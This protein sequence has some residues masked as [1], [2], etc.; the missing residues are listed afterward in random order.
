VD[1][2]QEVVVTEAIVLREGALCRVSPTELVPGDILKLESGVKVPADA[3]L[4]H[5]ADLRI[6]MSGLTGESL[7]V[8]RKVFENGSKDVE[9][10]HESPNMIFCSNVV[11]SGILLCASVANDF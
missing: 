4:F 8:E 10:A 3:I 6:D 2:K 9:E 5:V 11:T 1:L 7:P